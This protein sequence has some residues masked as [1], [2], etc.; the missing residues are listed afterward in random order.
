MESPSR[1]EILPM[2]FMN[3]NFYIEN[4]NYYMKENVSKKIKFLE[5]KKINE[6]TLVIHIRSGE[7]FNG[8]NKYPDYVQN[9]LKFYEILI[10]K[11][12]KVLIVSENKNNPVISHLLKNNKV[13]FQSSTL[14]NDFNTLYSAQN[15]ATSGVGTFG[16][17][18]GLMSKK[19]KNFYCTNIFCDFHINPKMLDKSNINIFMFEI[20]NYIQIGEWVGNK[21]NIDLMLSKN[22]KIKTPKNY[23]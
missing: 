9:P 14:E 2:K 19:L 21:K 23:E 16:I 18:A 13:N 17:S 5:E 8:K 10:D 22:I 11:F 20:E 1:N 3:S 7:I 15:L 12:E 6:D 4:A